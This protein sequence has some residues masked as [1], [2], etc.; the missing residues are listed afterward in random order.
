MTRECQAIRDL[1]DS[2]LSAELLVETNHEMLRHLGGCADCAAELGRRQRARALLKQALRIDLETDAMRRRIRAAI[3][4]DRR[5]LWRAKRWAI[6]AGL[7]LGIAVFYGR[8]SP[9]VEASAVYRDAVIDHIE[10]ALT[11]PA[12]MEYDAAR[13]ARRL[14][15]PFVTLP[16]SVGLGTRD[17]S[18]D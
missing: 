1:M 7:I 16:E 13:S 3:A 9:T 5:W 6:A 8:Y 17:V 2:Y 11:F 18:P 15:A 12:G 14:K 10:C 4:R